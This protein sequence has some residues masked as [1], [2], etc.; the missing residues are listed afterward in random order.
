[1]GIVERGGFAERD[2]WT[3]EEGEEE[4]GV[5]MACVVLPKQTNRS[6]LIA[7]YKEARTEQT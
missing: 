2:K 3:V 1:M 6:P 4:C 5:G 7:Q